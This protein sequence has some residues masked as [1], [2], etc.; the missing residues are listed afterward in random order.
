MAFFKKN[1]LARFSYD[2]VKCIFDREY[3]VR[4]G[5]RSDFVVVLVLVLVLVD[6]QELLS[7]K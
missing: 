3:E 6:F 1:Q 4:R 2:K 7:K 5:L